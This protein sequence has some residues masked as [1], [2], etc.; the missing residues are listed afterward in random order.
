MPPS[1]LHTVRGNRLK[2]A[3]PQPL[4]AEASLKRRSVRCRAM[5]FSQAYRETGPQ[6]RG[7]SHHC[8]RETGGTS[9]ASSSRTQTAP[10]SRFSA[11]VANRYANTRTRIAR[12]GAPPKGS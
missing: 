1:C 2:Q 6:T 7:S 4:L 9:V 10:V 8:P 5:S 3:D 12:G 11:R